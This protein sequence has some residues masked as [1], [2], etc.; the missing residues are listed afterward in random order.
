[1]Y[2][3]AV[4]EA[5]IVV[6]EA[7]DRICGKRLK[8]ALPYLVCAMERHGHLNLDASV[9]DR[10]LL[11]SA[12]TIDRLLAPVRSRARGRGSAKRRMSKKRLSKQIPVRTCSDWDDPIPGYLEID[13][14]VHSGG[15]MCGALIHSLAGTD[16]CSGW[17]ECVPL[18]VREQSLV[19]EGLK[20][21][22]ERAP[23]SLRGIDSDNDS[24]FINDTLFVFCQEQGIEFTRSRARRKNDQAWIEQKNGSIVRRFVGYDRFSGKV[25]GQLLARL[26]QAVRLYVNYFQPSF[27]LREKTRMGARV[28][29][30]YFKPAT[31]C[32]RLLQHPAIDEEIK[33]TLREQRDRLDPVELLHGIR[34]TQTALAALGSEDPTSGPG[35]E[36]MD[37]F[38]TELPRLWRAGEAR[39]TH[40]KAAAKPRAWRTRKDPFE[41]V[42]SQILF[43]LQKEPDAT[44]KCLFE[45]LQQEHPARFPDGQLRT[46][47]RRLRDWRQVMAQELI[48]GAS[49][50][51]I[52]PREVAFVEKG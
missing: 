21:I 18:L 16:V 23:F 3:S 43:W 42:W 15:S 46:L 34:N 29:K 38:R 51:P 30:R 52:E 39:P 25:A 26:Y 24:A 40:R 37:Q 49:A 28:R 9:R 22:R 27:K 12:A 45:R 35:R 11:V 44:A 8:A 47:Q 20:V 41:T 14:V 1:V 31:P 48:F 17:T 36:S 2:D 50:G 10:L 5:L 7:A 13:F 6:W 33:E 32:E 19:V 4:K